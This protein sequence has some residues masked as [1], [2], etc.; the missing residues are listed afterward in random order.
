MFF[1]VYQNVIFGC[2]EHPKHEQVFEK[3]SL[4]T[5]LVKFPS[6]LHTNIGAI[7]CECRSIICARKSLLEMW[8][9]ILR[10]IDH[11]NFGIIPSKQ[12]I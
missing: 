10:K 12:A 2:T 3:K 4:T 6:Q 7:K 5:C 1:S 9:I 11:F 8:E